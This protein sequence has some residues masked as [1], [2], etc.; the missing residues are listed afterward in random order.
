MLPCEGRGQLLFLVVGQT[1]PEMS[2]LETFH[3]HD[4]LRLV[5]Y[6]LYTPKKFKSQ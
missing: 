6:A 3:E 1:L 4:V 2:L 5:S